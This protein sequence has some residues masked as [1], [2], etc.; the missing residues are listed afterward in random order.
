M[1]LYWMAMASVDWKTPEFISRL[2]TL[3]HWLTCLSLF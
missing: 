3:F 1:T 2:S